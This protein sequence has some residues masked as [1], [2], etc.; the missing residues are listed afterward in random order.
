M[1][2]NT[3]Y[4]SD[5]ELM[6]GVRAAAAI[7]AVVGLDRND[8]DRDASSQVRL[9]LWRYLDSPASSNNQRLLFCEPPFP[10]GP[11]I[12]ELPQL[13]INRCLIHQNA[14]YRAVCDCITKNTAAHAFGSTWPTSQRSSAIFFISRLYLA[15]LFAHSSHRGPAPKLLRAL[16]LVPAAPWLHRL[17]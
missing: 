6:I 4:T 16:F 9:P 7:G 15:A 13:I 2:S 8:A 11:I 17:A 5:G 1:A 3:D 14:L 10:F 12:F